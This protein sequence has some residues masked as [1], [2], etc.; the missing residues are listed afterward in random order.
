MLANVATNLGLVLLL[1]LLTIVALLIRHYVPTRYGDFWRIW[2]EPPRN[3]LRFSAMFLAGNL[4]LA[5][6]RRTFTQPIV[7]W[8]QLRPQ[9]DVILFAAGIIALVIG[10]G[11]IWWLFRKTTYSKT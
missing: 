8:G 1:S 9:S 5:A 4:V 11:G 7:F 10:G 3:L 6:I 2:G